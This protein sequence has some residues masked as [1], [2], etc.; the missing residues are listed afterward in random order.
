[1]KIRLL[2]VGTATALYVLLALGEDK[3]PKDTQT[4]S[5]AKPSAIQPGVHY[6]K[7]AETL[8]TLLPQLHKSRD[9]LG[10]E[11][12]AIA[13]EQYFSSLDYDHTI[14]L[15]SD[16]DG[17]ESH[18]T[19]VDDEVK[20]GDLDFAYQVFEVFKKRVHGRVDFVGTILGKGFDTGKDEKYLWKRKDEPWPKDQAEQDDI[21]RK[22]IKH[23]YVSR[24]VSKKM[25]KE[26]AEEEEKGKKDEPKDK[27][28]NEI[29][30]NITELNK[31]EAEKLLKEKQE[32]AE[33]LSPEESIR[34]KYERFRTMIDGHDAEY[35]LQLYMNAFT[36]AY[37]SHTSFMPPRAIEDFNISMKL[38]LHGIGALLSYE[39]GA[40]EIIRVIPGGPAERDGRLH[41]G[42]RIIKV[43]QE[44]GSIDNILYWPLYK[45]VRKIRGEKGTKIVLHVQPKSSPDGDLVKIDLIRDVIKLDDKEAK[46]RISEFK[47]EGDIESYKIGIIDLPDFYAD[48]DNRDGRKGEP[49]SCATDVKKLLLDLVEQDVDGIVFDL[50]N[51]GGGSLPDCVELTGYFIEDGPV[52]QV[53]QTNRRPRPLMDPNRDIVYKG[54][55]VVLVNRQSASASEIFAAALQD[56]GRAIIVGD[57]KTHGKG[58]VQTLYPLDRGNNK[59][60]F[61]KVTTAG[62]FRIDGRSTQLKG[63]TPDII[64]PSSMDVMEVG[65]EYLDN[66]LPW[67][68]IGAARFRPS[69]HLGDLVENLNEASSKRR[70]KDPRFTAQ[71][72]FIERLQKRMAKTEVTLNLATRLT[73]ARADKELDKMQKEL[74]QGDDED[75]TDQETKDKND[76]VLGEGIYI[77]RDLIAIQSQI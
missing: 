47:G 19:T 15:Q 43:E 37:D 75:S 13:F 77:L 44:D 68:M 28:D 8:T 38:S 76:I 71:K 45:S 33:K 29:E 61:L 22:K 34:K 40:A 50:R 31:R 25:R 64:I 30:D 21:W 3:N 60:G 72:G 16:I 41:P 36:R 69:G 67:S 5:P 54:P 32:L 35:V 10:D 62:F 49:K 51:N 46:S 18:I 24:V 2:L 65:E 74:E 56:Y 14:F 7:I 70:D 17:F 12:A 48:M 73:E 11:K 4:A 63:V 39:E 55:M 53:Q 66:V 57:T 20:E 6:P 1:M 59:M 23:E 9:K 52:V 58:S 26:N 42:D 27:A